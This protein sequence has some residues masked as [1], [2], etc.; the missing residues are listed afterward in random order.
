M[1]GWGPPPHPKFL[2]ILLSLKKKIIKHFIVWAPKNNEL[3][4][5]KNKTKC[6]K[7]LN[8][9]IQEDQNLRN[10]KLYY[11]DHVNV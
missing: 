2:I 4:C 10:Q 6:V 7:S 11:T 3:L 5:V 1:L 8:S 9:N